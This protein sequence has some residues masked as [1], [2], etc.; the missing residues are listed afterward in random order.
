MYC[1]IGTIVYPFSI[2]IVITRI[3]FDYY[4]IPNYFI[5]IN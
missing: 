5:I 2:N 3:M 4:K 1:D